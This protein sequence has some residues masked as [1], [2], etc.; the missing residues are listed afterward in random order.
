[1]ESTVLN[2]FLGSC[3]EAILTTADDLCFKSYKRQADGIPV[4]SVLPLEEIAADLVM[5]DREWGSYQATKHLLELGH[6]RVAMLRRGMDS[7]HGIARFEGYC[8]ALKEY[9]LEVDESLIFDLKGVD[10]LKGGYE[11]GQA[12]AKSN[13]GITAVFCFSDLH[14]IGAMTAFSEA[15][16][17]IP[18][19]ISIVG[20]DD[21]AVAA[22]GLVPLTT[23]VWPIRECAEKIVEWMMERIEGVYRATGPRLA[24]L[25]P[26]LVVR[27]STAP[28]VHGRSSRKKEI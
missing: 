19:D 5:V 25:K 16:L 18:E 8:R 12:L 22:Y 17:R 2:D 24:N 1:M 15:G 7:F 4:I 20:F 23:V 21:I 6:R 3:V 26:E 11:S 14:A 9:G 27:K 13:A 28:L 10:D